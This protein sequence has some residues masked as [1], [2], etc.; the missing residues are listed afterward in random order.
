MKDLL[1]LFICIFLIHEF[2]EIIFINSWFNKQRGYLNNRFPK[3]SKYIINNISGISTPAFALAVFEEYLI[4]IIVAFFSI[5]FEN[6]NLIIGIFMGFFIHLIVHIVQWIIIRKYIPSILSSFIC[7]P[8]CIWILKRII[9][10]QVVDCYD[11]I[12]W[13]IIGIS[14]TTL[15]LL[16]VHYI[17]KILD[18]KYF[19]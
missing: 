6:Y 16:L 13:S 2:E 9:V 7:I 8:F 18:K 17:V 12:V 19:V 5:Y 1:F 14:I 11:I 15:N 4:I 10:L 3:L